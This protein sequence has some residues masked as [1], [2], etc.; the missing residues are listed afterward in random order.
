[1]IAPAVSYDLK[2]KND[3][4]LVHYFENPVSEKLSDPSR[5]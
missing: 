1:V 3:I 5:V 4:L 2:Q